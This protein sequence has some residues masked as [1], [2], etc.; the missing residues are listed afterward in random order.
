MTV[1]NF[2]IVPV[3]ED[4]VNKGILQDSYLKKNAQN[5]PFYNVIIHKNY[6]LL[7]TVTR[8]K[9]PFYAHRFRSISEYMDYW[10]YMRHFSVNLTNII[11]FLGHKITNPNAQGADGEAIEQLLMGT[12]NDKKKER[13]G[14]HAELKYVKV[15]RTKNK[16]NISFNSVLRIGA[17][18][19]DDLEKSKFFDTD[20]F[21]MKLESL[22]LGLKEIYG[23]GDL[24]HIDMAFWEQ[25]EDDL[26]IDWNVSRIAY[27]KLPKIIIPG[28]KLPTAIGPKGGIECM[29]I[30]QHKGKNTSPGPYLV[31]RS[32][33]LNKHLNNL[34]NVITVASSHPLLKFR[35][36]NNF[37][38]NI[39]PISNGIQ[40]L[41]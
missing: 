31:I 17:I 27:S 21:Q 34:S 23:I 22:L 39:T 16:N 12:I 26:N 9:P 4:L 35:P 20:I 30:K 41:F 10:N 15:N 13:D 2:D 18:S 8:H 38:V 14:L 28:K 3:I 11:P 6:E 29:G 36:T 1:H 24:H 33:F 5:L 25:Y 7:A 37:N 19:D 32:C 40:Q